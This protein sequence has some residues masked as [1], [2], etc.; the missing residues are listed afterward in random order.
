MRRNRTVVCSLEGGGLRLFESSFARGHGDPS[1]FVL[2]V[3]RFNNMLMCTDIMKTVME[4]SSI[5]AQD[6]LSPRC[7]AL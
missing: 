1:S 4:E 6:S 3:A 5:D 2:L 7:F